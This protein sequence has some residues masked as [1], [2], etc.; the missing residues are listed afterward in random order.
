MENGFSFS[1]LLPDYTVPGIP[2]V[3]GYIL[4]A[5]CGVALSIIIFRLAAGLLKKKS[6]A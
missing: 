6:I 5:I 3:V 2:E 4:S 1:A